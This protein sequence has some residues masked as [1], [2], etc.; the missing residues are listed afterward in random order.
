MAFF[1]QD[2]FFSRAIAFWGSKVK[3]SRATQPNP[4][5]FLT[6]LV[7]LN[8]WI[9]ADPAMCAQ[10]VAKC[11][12]IWR[13]DVMLISITDL[14]TC[15]LVSAAF[16]QEHLDGWGGTRPRCHQTTAPV[17]TVFS[18]PELSR[19]ALLNSAMCKSG[20]TERH[21]Y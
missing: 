18:L 1:P 7:A 5:S 6:A 13:E 8:Q 2:P 10:R 19:P 21:R 12:F 3:A 14:A 20:S 16:I 4:A 17:C 11:G 15:L 9:W